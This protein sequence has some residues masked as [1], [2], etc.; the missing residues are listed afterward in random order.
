MVNAYELAHT[1]TREHN[2]YMYFSS[3]TIPFLYFLAVS[4]HGGK[5]LAL[6]PNPSA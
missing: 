3:G 1:W 5:R 4:P 6:L 2:F